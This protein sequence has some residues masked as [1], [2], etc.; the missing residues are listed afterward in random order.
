MAFS[1]DHIVT[2][3][4]GV[5][6]PLAIIQRLID[7]E[8]RGCTFRLEAEGRFRVTPPSALTPDDAA[9]L[10]AHRDDAR[11]AIQYCEQMA[12]TPQ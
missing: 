10:S 7:L 12:A 5:T 6:M 11:R 1:S 4:G 9:F 3:K 8:D 2:L